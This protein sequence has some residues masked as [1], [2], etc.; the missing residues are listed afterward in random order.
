MSGNRHGGSNPSLS[1]ILRSPAASFGWAGQAKDVSPKRRSR[2]S[3][4]ATHRV[5][6][7]PRLRE[8]AFHI[9]DTFAVSLLEV[10][11]SIENVSVLLGHSSVRITERHYKPWVKTLQKKLEDE[12]RKAWA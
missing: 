3:I 6:F 7:R 5:G 2:D 8:A 1:A 4:H 10:G 12:V 9:R 11:V